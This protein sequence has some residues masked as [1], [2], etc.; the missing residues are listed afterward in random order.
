M[1]IWIDVDA[2]EV[3]TMSRLL[4]RSQLPE[5]RSWQGPSRS[6]ASTTTSPRVIF[7]GYLA[8]GAPV[9]AVV[10]ALRRLRQL[11]DLPPGLFGHS[12][13]STDSE[14]LLVDGGSPQ[15][16]TQFSDLIDGI[17]ALSPRRALIAT[18]AAQSVWELRLGLEADKD[19]AVA[20][21]RLR[22]RQ[23]VRGGRTWAKP[24]VLDRDLRAARARACPAAAGASASSN[25]EATLLIIFRGP[26]GADPEALLTRMI[27]AICIHAA[28][29]L[30]CADSRRVLPPGH[31][32]AVRDAASQWTGSLRMQLADRDA[33]MHLATKL[34]QFAV[35]VE[36][37][38]GILDV[39]SPYLPDWLTTP[40]AAFSQQAPGPPL[41]T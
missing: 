14:T 36:G 8:A 28:V 4:H 32:M 31:W 27:T 33:A 29:D 7:T 35:R 12:A 30:H 40:T 17:V 21:Q 1:S 16:W 24:P 6:P 41:S 10:L 34:R 11:R 25:P 5:V 22:W 13:L 39:H 9:M 26:L 19:P 18:S 20:V 38:T 2:K 15:A 3:A 23:S 37:V